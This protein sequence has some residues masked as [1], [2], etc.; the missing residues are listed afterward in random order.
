MIKKEILNLEKSKFT[1]LNLDENESEIKLNKIIKAS[2]GRKYN[3][4]LDSVHWKLFSALSLNQ[5]RYK[6]ILEIGT[7]D[8]QFTYFLF[9]NVSKSLITTID[10]YQKVILY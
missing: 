4:D 8:G 3:S 5:N 1:K 6:K 2:I 7:Y 10:I 9:E